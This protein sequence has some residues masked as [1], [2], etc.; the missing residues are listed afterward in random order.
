MKGNREQS[1]FSVTSVSAANKVPGRAPPLLYVHLGLSRQLKVQSP[2]PA[3]IKRIPCCEFFKK[4]SVCFDRA[5]AM[6]RG[7]MSQ[8]FVYFTESEVTLSCSNGRCWEMRL[9]DSTHITACSFYDLH[10]L[11]K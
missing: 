3:E 8:Y 4:A 2:V 6:I 5:K 9:G 10:T 11:V 7:I 1:L